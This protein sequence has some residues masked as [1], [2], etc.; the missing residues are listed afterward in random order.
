MKWG[1]W[2]LAWESCAGKLAKRITQAGG[3]A[4]SPALSKCA[5]WWQSAM[6]R[7]FV[8]GRAQRP[9][10][11]IRSW[12]L[13]RGRVTQRYSPAARP[14]APQDCPSACAD[15]PLPTQD[16]NVGRLLCGLSSPARSGASAHK[17]PVPSLPRR[18][19][20]RCGGLCRTPGRSWRGRGRF[21][22]CDPWIRGLPSLPSARLWG[23]PDW[24]ILE[25][26]L[27]GNLV[28]SSLGILGAS[29]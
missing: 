4:R 5:P 1:R 27:L 20:S 26:H 29:S 2:P 21:S 18:P 13:S 16:G 17:G 15:Q 7:A 8:S 11:R 24:E 3:S 12:S 9:A 6:T 10:G 19:G 22:G 14:R 28:P 25:C 23:P